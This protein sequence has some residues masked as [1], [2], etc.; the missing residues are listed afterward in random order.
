MD[1]MLLLGIGGGVVVVIL[2]VVIAVVAVEGQY[3]HYGDKFTLHMT[4]GGDVSLSGS[5]VGL[6]VP[7]TFMV[8]KSQTEKGSGRLQTNAPFT[9]MTTDGSGNNWHVAG[10]TGGCAVV[11]DKSANTFQMQSKASDIDK[12]TQNPSDTTFSFPVGDIKFGDT[13]YIQIKSGGCDNGDYLYY[14]TDSE[15]F[16]PNNIAANAATFKV[17]KA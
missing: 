1:P 8:Q 17:Q 10:V 12:T 15:T 6:G 2:I 9:V 11:A 3:L 5:Q 7:A 16:A 13:M 14:I 4:N